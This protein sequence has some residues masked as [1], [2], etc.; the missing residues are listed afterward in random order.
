MPRTRYSTP[1]DPDRC[2]AWAKRLETLIQQLRE[3]TADRRVCGIVLKVWDESY[4]FEES[5]LT[6]RQRAEQREGR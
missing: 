5:D 6:D 4:V 2:E 1:L 3:P